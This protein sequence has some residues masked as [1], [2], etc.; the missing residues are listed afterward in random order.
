MLKKGRSQFRN[1]RTRAIIWIIFVKLDCQVFWLIVYQLLVILI[2]TVC[3]CMIFFPGGG[4]ANFLNWCWGENLKVYLNWI[5]T[6]CLVSIISLFS[7]K[8][9]KYHEELVCSP[10]PK[11]EQFQTLFKLSLF[12]LKGGICS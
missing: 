8:D 11:N 12:M 4:V 1:D 6:I 5:F 3:H 7:L 10:P 2:R 9:I